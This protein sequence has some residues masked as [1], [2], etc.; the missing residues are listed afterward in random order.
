MCKVCII[1]DDWLVDVI[2]WDQQKFCVAILQ[3]GS[4]WIL[5]EKLQIW[6]FLHIIL[7]KVEQARQCV[8]FLV[9]SSSSNTVCQVSICSADGDL[10]S[11]IFDQV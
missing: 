8:Y 4:R 7:V 3:L 10:A 6:R 11:R 1:Y 9:C 5:G 2:D